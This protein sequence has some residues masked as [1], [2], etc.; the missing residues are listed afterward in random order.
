MLGTLVEVA[1]AAGADA[2]GTIEAAFQAIESVEHALSA[3]RAESDISRFHALPAGQSLVVRP[4]TATVLAAAQDLHEASGGV[5]DVALQCAPGGWHCDGTR[6]FKHAQDTRIELA[7]IAKGHAVDRAVEAL[8]SLDVRSGWVN[9]GGDLR[10]FGQAEVA[11][12][13]RDEERG[14][15]R[16]FGHLAEGAFATSHFAA[17]SRS[18]ALAP[19]GGTV[20]AHA[21]VAAPRCLW[22]DALTKVVALTGCCDAAWLDRYGAHAWLH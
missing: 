19:G 6:L 7:G 4:D 10:A 5:F 14:G 16:L 21:S 9:A 11:L 18:Q 17:A 13:L 22:A 3:F 8:Q 12:Q 20:H 1:V 15:T 2:D